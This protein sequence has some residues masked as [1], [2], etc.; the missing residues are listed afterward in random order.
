[1]VSMDAMSVLIVRLLGLS[2]AHRLGGTLDVGEE[3]PITFTIT[4]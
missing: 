1:M 4:Q 2:I 3:W